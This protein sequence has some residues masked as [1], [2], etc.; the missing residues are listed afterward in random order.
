MA[1]VYDEQL[2]VTTPVIACKVCGRPMC[3]SLTAAG[4]RCPYDVV[5]NEPTRV[6]HFTSCPKVREWTAAHPKGSV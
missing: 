1:T 6:S 5:D 4:K 3:F 2:R